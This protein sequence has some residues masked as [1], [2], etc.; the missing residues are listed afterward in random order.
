MEYN[1][2]R[3]IIRQKDNNGNVI[4]LTDGE[5]NTRK[6]E[7]DLNSNL[8]AVYDAKGVLTESYTYDCLGNCIGITDALGNVTKNSYDAMGN[9]I[10]QMNEAT[11]NAVTYSY[12]G[13]M[14]L[15]S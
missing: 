8:T 3:K 13:G 1:V 15:A 7:Y 4:S 2:Y 6:M 14:Y 10:K 12:V 5:G 9:L 11:G